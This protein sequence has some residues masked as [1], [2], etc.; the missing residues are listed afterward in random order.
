MHLCAYYWVG[1]DEPQH[2]HDR[3]AKVNDRGRIE[4]KDRS[5]INDERFLIRP[6][7]EINAD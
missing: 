6:M 2:N 5:I 7:S 4:R 3:Q 1:L